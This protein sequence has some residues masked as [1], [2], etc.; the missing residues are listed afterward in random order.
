V[1]PV[2]ALAAPAQAHPTRTKKGR[3]HGTTTV[4]PRPRPWGERELDV[5]AA[6]APGFSRGHGSDLRRP[7]AVLK[8]RAVPGRALLAGAHALTMA[9]PVSCAAGTPV[10]TITVANQA[11]V[12]PWALARVERAVVDQSLQLRAAWGTPCVQF[13]AGGW[14]VYLQTGYTPEPEGATSFALGGK[15]Y[16]A[17]YEGSLWVGQPY[18]VV[19]TGALPYANWSFAFSH[20]IMGNA[21]RSERHNSLAARAPR[22]L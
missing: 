16:G 15:H 1:L 7:G 10:Q 20:E 6:R 12:R 4:V 8:H 18:A 5:S 2:L 14:L 19:R 22:G 17:A 9:A 3:N 11:N 13:G 21:R